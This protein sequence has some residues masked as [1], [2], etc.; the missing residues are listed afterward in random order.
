MFS[1]VHSVKNEVL[2][3]IERVQD[4]E[5]AKNFLERNSITTFAQ[6]EKYKTDKGKKFDSREQIFIPKWQ[7]LEQLKEL[8]KAYADY[9]P[10][11]AVHDMSKSLSDLKK[12]KYDKE[13]E[14]E[15]V[16]YEN[17]RADLKT[18]LAEWEKITPKAWRTEKEQLEKE[19]PA[20]RS[21]RTRACHDLAFAEVISYNKANLE[22]VEQSESRQRNR[23]QT[24]SRTVGR[25]KRR[26]EEL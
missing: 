18:L 26:E 10:Y 7:R 25:T 20:L 21:E 22:R 2:E 3:M 16:M 13:H 4:V 9:E 5:N 8:A 24:V 19:M 12:L 11:K 6:L 15:L 1:A 23:Q 17:T 14:H